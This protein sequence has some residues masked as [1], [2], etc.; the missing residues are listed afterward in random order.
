[1]DRACIATLP[2]GVQPI[3]SPI[4]TMSILKK[5]ANSNKADQLI[6]GEHAS[7]LSYDWPAAT[8]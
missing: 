1:M 5:Q 8:D 4:K 6:L 3:P 2:D 7:S